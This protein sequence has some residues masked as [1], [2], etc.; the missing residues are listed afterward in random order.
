MNSY[1]KRPLIILIITLLIFSFIA[2]FA[3]KDWEN[4]DVFLMGEKWYTHLY[5]YGWRGLSDGY[6]AI[7]P[8]SYLYMLWASTF[9]DGITGRLV[10]MKIIP[11]IF[12]I[13]GMFF[14]FRVARLKY[15]TGDMPYALSTIYF[16][17]LTVMVN[18]SGWGQIDSCYTIFLILCVYFLVKEKPFR[19]MT[20]FGLAFSFKAHSIFLLPFLAIML[21][22]GKVRLHHFLMIPIIY[23]I[24]ALPTVLIGRSWVSVFDVYP[25]QVAQFKMLSYNAPNPYIFIPNKFYEA[26]TIIGLIIFFVGI[27]AWIWLNWRSS[28]PMT[29]SDIILMAFTSLALVP[30]L[31][32]KMHERYFYPADVFSLL[33]AIFL[34]EMWIITLFYQISSGISYTIYF[35]RTPIILA[36]IGAVINTISIFFIL[37]KQITWALS[38]TPTSKET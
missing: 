21:L 25:R 2:R 36:M 9:L 22:K 24:F 28:R 23:L 1:K 18:S 15:E 6:L 3:I 11:T 13:F 33:N 32:P 17:L 29:Y 14:V 27:S 8:P 30:F 37:K 34:P 26:G 4:V 12:D 7:Y 5:T 10:A 16:S 20:A 38:E 31:L 19:A 35:L